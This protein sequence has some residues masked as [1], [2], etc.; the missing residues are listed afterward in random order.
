MKQYI[1]NL[2]T[3][4]IELHFEK[5]EYMALTDA[6]K[7]ELKSYFSWS[8]YATAWVSKSTKDHY[9]AKQIAAKLGFAEE[10]K[11]G[12]RLSFAEE[13]ERKAEKAG[14]RAE[15]MEEHA[16]N[17]ERRGDQMTAP[18]NSM[19]GDIAFFTQP[20]INSSAGRAFTNY[21]NRL[22]ERSHKGFEEY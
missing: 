13:I 21:R 20:N 7:S 6:Q 15:R 5:S 8:K 9:Y 4:H 3:G 18:L 1:N 10:E 11:H 12:E 16:E 22:Y 14:H 19:H 2:E 17:A